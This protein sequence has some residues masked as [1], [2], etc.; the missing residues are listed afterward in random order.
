[1]E[2]C[3]RK[4]RARAVLSIAVAAFA[5]LSV[6]IW[7]ARRDAGLDGNLLYVARVSQLMTYFAI[8]FMFRSH[9][10][11]IKRLLAVSYGA[12]LVHMAAQAAL[13]AFGGAPGPAF[14]S[15]V[16]SGIAN[17]V[18]ILLIMHV[19]SSY[20]ARRSSLAVMAAY[21]LAEVLFAATS[22]MSAEAI[23]V[24]QYAF[25]LCGFALL[26]LAIAFKGEGA[27]TENEHP[28]QYGMLTVRQRDEKPL[29]LLVNEADWVFQIIVA[30]LIPFVFGF[31]SQ[32]LSQAGRSDGLHDPVN[33]AAAIVALIAL[34][35]FCLARGTRMGF[36]DLFL[37]VVSLYATGLMLLP[38]LWEAGSPFAGTF[39]KCGDVVYFPLL[40]MLLVRKAFADPRHT[41][42]YFG[43]FSGFANVT[44]GRLVGP[45]ALGPTPSDTGTVAFWALVF[46]WLLVLICV[47]LFALQ[48]ARGV[49]LPDG[50]EGDVS[51]E[52][53]LI[54][55]LSQRGWTCLPSGIGSRPASGRC[56]WRCCTATACPTWVRSC[57]FPPRRCA[58]IC[59]T[60][61]GR[62]ACRTSRRLF[63]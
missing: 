12:A 47:T 23:V 56:W 33:E 34:F 10:P 1:M 22:V 51:A 63:G 50:A 13:G 55:S 39:I 35:A 15:N 17:A 44:Y 60:S 27:A 54:G 14:A 61:I 25:K 42:L 5:L 38:T 3:A 37:I 49:A 62:R 16:V 21:L 52:A 53:S 20:D 57:S 30:A 18:G 8:A 48:R 46:L 28:L 43:V 26:G 40:W 32:L 59:A 9:L 29:R 58:P 24:V 36:D 4:R 11:S 6:G 2:D 45:L 31:T 7:T 41:Y 19:I